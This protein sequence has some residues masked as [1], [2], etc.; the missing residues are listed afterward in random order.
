MKLRALAFILIITC[1]ALGSFYLTPYK[2]ASADD[3]PS[4]GLYL[5][6]IVTN[7]CSPFFDSFDDPATEW[8]TG[9]A[10]ALRAE[11]TGGEY[12]LGLSGGGSVGLVPGP[13]CA[14]S[15]YQV[16]VDARWA[17]QPGNFIGLLVELD[18]ANRTAYL[19][20]VNTDS[21]VWIVFKV[22]GDSLDTVIDPIKND[23]VLPGGSVNRLTV[24][25]RDTTLYFSVN[26]TPVGELRSG[27]SG[28]PVLAGVAAASYTT[29]SAVDA[30]FDNFHWQD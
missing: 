9:T 2:S 17:G 10:G 14:L 26:D 29:Q 19:F 5:P 7:P 6:I 18:E 12:K 25:S 4:I 8:F 23:A 15:S 30:R 3:T 24:E 28:M 27:A 13:M 16:A 22:R 1:T 21:Q 20:A 11:V